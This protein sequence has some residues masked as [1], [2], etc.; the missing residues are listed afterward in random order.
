MSQGKF[1]LLI[2]LIVGRSES[3]SDLPGNLITIQTAIST[4]EYITGALDQ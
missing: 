3:D 2:I 1:T 4:F